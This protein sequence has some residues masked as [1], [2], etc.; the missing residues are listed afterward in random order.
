MVS[1]PTRVFSGR[2]TLGLHDHISSNGGQFETESFSLEDMTLPSNLFSV[3]G[4][5][6]NQAYPYHGIY[7]DI[8]GVCELSSYPGYAMTSAH[9]FWVPAQ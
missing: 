8:A 4:G 3:I 2:A 7:G 9:S 5:T 1:L 6:A